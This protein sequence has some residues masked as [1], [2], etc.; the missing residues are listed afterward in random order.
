MPSPVLPD[1]RR[2]LFPNMLCNSR[3]QDLEESARSR[4]HA[5]ITVRTSSFP[6][7]WVPAVIRSLKSRGVPPP[8]SLLSVASA[9]FPEDDSN[10]L[11]A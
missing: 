2:L 10:L 6:V 9:H 11:L 1:L 4:K 3:I 7:R 8:S 5:A